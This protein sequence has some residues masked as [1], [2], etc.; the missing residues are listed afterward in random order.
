MKSSTK[1]SI[2]YLLV[3]VL[4]IIT[5]FFMNSALSAKNNGMKMAED[6]N[7]HNKSIY[8]DAFMCTIHDCEDIYIKL[9]RMAESSLYCA[10]F[11]FDLETLNSEIRKAN[12]VAK[13]VYVDGDNRHFSDSYI[14]YEDKSSYMHNK[15]C[16][17]DNR[18][19]IT[20]SFNPTINGRDKND[21]NVVVIFSEEVARIYQEYFF[22]L[23]REHQSGYEYRSNISKNHELE[24]NNIN[25]SICFSRG[26]NC[27]NKIEKELKRSNQSINFMLFT[28][29]DDWLGTILLMKHYFNKEKKKEYVIKGIFEKS[30]IT[31]YS[32]FHKLDFH[33]LYVIK[34]CNKGKL[35]HKVIIIDNSTVVTGSLNPSYNADN[36]NDENMLV[37]KSLEIAEK[38]L[39]EF[40]RIE[41]LCT[42]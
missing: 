19:T 20:G 27:L 4:V 6:D 22:E 31:K 42:I 16:V 5:L 29:T 1:V 26:G 30:L 33:N 34:D 8:A 36:R 25:L 7:F 15:F 38:Y 41:A 28:M 35:H 18:I 9:I 3:I 23:L 14:I 12:D 21:N 24:F 37:I 17:I 2:R 39:K 13:I 10:F 32:E 40:S 11:D